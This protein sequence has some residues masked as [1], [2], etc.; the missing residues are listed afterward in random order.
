MPTATRPADRN[1]TPAAERAGPGRQAS[2]LV[3][4][5]GNPLLGDDGVGWSIVDAFER[6][7]S[8]R[9]APSRGRQR[10]GP[11]PG[12]ASVE[13]DRLSVGGLRLM[14]RLLGY[15]RAIVVD[16]GD[17]GDV[18]AGSVRVRRLDE[19]PDRSTGHLGSAH[20]ASLQTALAAARALGAA[21]PEEV[22][23]L[24]VEARPVTTFTQRLT[25]AVGAAVGPAV[26]RLLDLCG[27]AADA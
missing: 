21:P 23:V 8:L 25:P 22:I 9:T 12:V 18:P 11:Q 16:A 24:T 3:V 7:L 19:L 15:R 4:G 6:R 27:L 26:E 13:V 1:A 14:E 5:L 17:G 10:R 2:T 20:D